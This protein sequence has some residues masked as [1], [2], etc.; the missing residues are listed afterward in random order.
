MNV[1]RYTPIDS[2]IFDLLELLNTREGLPEE[3]LPETD[4]L[5]AREELR[6]IEDHFEQ[7]SQSWHH[8][9]EEEKKRLVSR[10]AS[11]MSRRVTTSRQA[12]GDS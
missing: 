4:E 12:D 10:V 1:R 8:F 3:D 9:S 2:G 11:M 5:H 7:S 6:E